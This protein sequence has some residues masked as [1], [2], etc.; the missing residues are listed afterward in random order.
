ML[1][2]ILWFYNYYVSLLP[3]GVFKG[4]FPLPLRVALRGVAWRAIVIMKR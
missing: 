2:Y 1:S 3:S 4:P